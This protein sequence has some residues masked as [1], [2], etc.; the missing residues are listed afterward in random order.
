MSSYPSVSRRESNPVNTADR[1]RILIAHQGCVP[2]YRQPFFD[3]LA[4]IEEFEYVIACG[5]P[6]RGSDYIVA[7]RP[8]DF[9][10]LAVANKELSFGRRSVIWQPLVRHFWR[11][12]D[13]VILGDEAKYLSHLAIII[14]AKIRRKPVVLWGF[15]YGSS[16]KTF[17]SRG[18]V[19]G[20]IPWLGHALRATRVRL[21]D[22]YLAYTDAGV[23]ALVASG[24]PLDRIAL[25]Q[26]TVDMEFQ[27]RLRD[28]IAREPE[29][30]S[31]RALGLPREGPVL[32]YFGRFIPQK[33]IEL[34]IDYVRHCKEA[35]RLVSAVIYGSGVER[36]KLIL[37]AEGLETVIFRAAIDDR[38]L[39]R[40]LRV[41]SAV[42]VPG[43]IGLAITHGFA[44]GVPMITREGK[45]APEI[46][47]LSPGENGLMLPKGTAAF[48]RGL[49]E[50]LADLALQKHLRAGAKATAERLSMDVS[51]S[52]LTGLVQRLLDRPSSP[53]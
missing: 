34:L 44:H 27:Y 32:L 13:A 22:G 3:R 1:P 8:Y 24:F 33:R 38:A 23:A 15:G 20:L 25:M 16:L 50:Y 14:A 35:G 12:F 7:Q 47:Y 28:E 48:F 18:L 2:I 29:A 45:H 30:E 39:T 53:H 52:A 46:T 42:V 41:S 36:E 51:V 19:R 26:N 21:A 5:A 4:K 17:R 40:A 6:P 11:E 37:R 9:P 43:Y 49:D 10:T 31:R